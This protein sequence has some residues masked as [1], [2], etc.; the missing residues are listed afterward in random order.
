MAS[1]TNFVRLLLL[2][3]VIT[4]AGSAA[5]QDEL[6]N[7]FFKDADAALT[8]ADAVNARLY[9]P[10]AYSDGAEDYE[11]AEVGLQ[12]GR[13]IEYV[14]RKTAEAA[15]S[16]RQA[17]QS[18]ELAQTAL[19]QVI[20]SRQDA[21]NAKAPELSRDVWDKAQREFGSAIRYLERGDLK[22]AK[23]KDIEATSL[24]RDA[25]LIAI[26]A[27]YLSETRRLLADADR[28]RVGRYAP[29]TLGFAQRLLADAERELNENRYD[30]D[31]PRS[32]ARQANYQAK[33]AIYLSE[34]VRKVR[35]KDLTV[36]QL[37]LEWEEPLSNIAGVADIT[38][39]M[40]E[41][42]AEIELD[43]INY[44]EDLQQENQSLEQEVDSNI[45]RL[46][47]MEEE[48]RTL[49]ER[50]GGATEERAAL[51]QRLEAQALIKAQFEQVEKMFSRNEARVFREGDNVILRLV[52]L[53]FD[54]GKA[55]IKQ[56]DF[57]LLAKIEKAIDMFPRSEL[58]IEGH[59]DSYGGDQSNQ[60]LSQERAESVQQY[61]INAMRLPSYRLIATGYG[62]TNPVANNETESGRARNRRIDIVIK[63]NLDPV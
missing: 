22:A 30:T 45:L 39:A 25:E 46:A 60:R 50:L 56:Q 9:G 17:T 10:A 27:Q 51:V 36:E 5:A 47:D 31:L 40:S 8:A 1:K 16:F 6:R 62:E 26:K 42:H 61:M 19:S 12:R 57:D 54:S 63:P 21:A 13:N 7:T 44:I 58:I 34:V 15:A 53:T 41:G 28:A 20:K 24:Y 55:E 18:A 2:A 33:H 3:L 48:I 23:R 52:G 29:L 14:R 49:D 38:P 59:T 43:L 37:V 35:D 4:G 11:A 32:L